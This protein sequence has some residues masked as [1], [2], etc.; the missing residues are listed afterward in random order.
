MSSE[1]KTRSSELFKAIKKDDATKI[2]KIIA[3]DKEDINQKSK[4]VVETY[5]PLQVAIILGKTK[6]LRALLTSQK[7][8]F[9]NSENPGSEDPEPPLITAMKYN[10]LDCLNILLDDDRVNV[11]ASTY[12]YSFTPLAYAISHKKKECFEALLKSKKAKDID[13]NRSC[14]GHTALGLSLTRSDA[15][16][17]ETLL[18]HPKLSVPANSAYCGSLVIP[19]IKRKFASNQEALSNLE[20]A[21]RRASNQE[22]EAPNNPEKATTHA[23]NQ[24]AKT[25]SNNL[26]KA[27]TRANPND[28][29]S[30]Y[31]YRLGLFLAIATPVIFT[32]GGI[33]IPVGFVRKPQEAYNAFEKLHLDSLVDKLSN[34][35]Q[36]QIIA[37]SIGGILLLGL[38][39]G[40]YIMIKKNQPIAEE[41]NR[42][43]NSLF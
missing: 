38:L 43:A 17:L 31:I 8:D 14:E 37:G 39:L 7:I 2:R 33:G 9:N 40:S 15:F 36:A 6:A 3:A 13:V 1:E 23:S 30:K 5:T 24:E 26:E 10:Q 21:I 29:K 20:N 18:R 19:I 16:Y 22:A 42:P 25:P 34:S 41:Q 27:T 12:A 11:N 32:T 4:G 28:G 35:T